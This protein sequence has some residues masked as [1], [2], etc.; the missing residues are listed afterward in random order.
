[1]AYQLEYEFLELKKYKAKKRK[2][3]HI[4]FA[5]ILLAAAVIFAQFGGAALEIIILGRSNHIGSAATQMV[6]HLQEGMTFDEAVYVFCE[7]ITND[8]ISN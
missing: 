7:E 2:N 4:I 5:S 8:E 1:M 3:I 6:A